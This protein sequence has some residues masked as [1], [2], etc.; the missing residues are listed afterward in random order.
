M[1]P[2]K[3]VLDPGTGTIYSFPDFYPEWINFPEFP[4]MAHQCRE[5][6]THSFKERGREREGCASHALQRE[7]SSFQR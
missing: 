2:D 5:R 6:R 3:V 1:F 4:D 7:L